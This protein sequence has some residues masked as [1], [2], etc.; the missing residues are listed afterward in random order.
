M[1]NFPASPANGASYTPVG[2]PTLTWDGTAWKAL[3]QGMPVTVFVGD[4]APTAP[5]FGNLWW[6]SDTGNLYIYYND[7]DS[8][9]WVQINGTPA[10]YQ[11]ADSRNRIVNGAMQISQESGFT[12]VGHMAYPA[13]QFQLQSAVP[14]VA[15]ARQASGVNG[16]AAYSIY[17]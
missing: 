17:T 7:G 12:P 15:A 1:F 8:A 11:T 3:S 16:P 14:T 6:E 10:G 2:G 9:Q 4:V 5:A 13:D